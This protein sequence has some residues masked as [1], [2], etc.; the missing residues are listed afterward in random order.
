MPLLRSLRIFGTDVL[1]ICRAYGAGFAKDA[2]RVAPSPW[3]EGRVE[4]GRGSLNRTFMN[5]CFAKTRFAK[6]LSLIIRTCL[7]NRVINS[8]PIGTVESRLTE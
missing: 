6:L 2:A 8:S 7:S 4:G 1:Q 3:G 5:H